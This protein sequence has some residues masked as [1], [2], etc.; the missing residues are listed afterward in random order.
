MN[1]SSFSSELTR[2][3]FDEHARPLKLA[4]INKKRSQA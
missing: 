4:R 2:T 3:V 1:D